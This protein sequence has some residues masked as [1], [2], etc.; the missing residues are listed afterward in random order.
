MLSQYNCVSDFILTRMHTNSHSRQLL[1]MAKYRKSLLSTPHRSIYQIR[2]KH[3]VKVKRTYITDESSPVQ[4]AGIDHVTYQASTVT[5]ALCRVTGIPD[6][7]PGNAQYSYSF[8][9][10]SPMTCYTGQAD[11]AAVSCRRRLE[12]LNGYNKTLERPSYSNK[13][14]LKYV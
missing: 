12:H 14:V 5:L 1:V 3:I 7:I 10:C 2:Q 11:T 8:S 4:C 9:P 13:H 6:T